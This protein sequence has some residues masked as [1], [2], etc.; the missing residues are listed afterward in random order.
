[1]PVQ[2]PDSHALLPPTGSWQTIPQPPHDSTSKAMS[3][4][5]E[6]RWVWPAGHVVV[7]RAAVQVPP[8]QIGVALGHTLP[9]VP[10]AEGSVVTS[11]Q[12]PVG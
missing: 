5:E 8:M 2:V 4:H 6:P 12:R 1:M 11:T 7:V 3:T 10:H 9:H